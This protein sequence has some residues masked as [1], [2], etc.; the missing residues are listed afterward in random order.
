MRKEWN[1]VRTSSLAHIHIYT[2]NKCHFS[3]TFPNRIH[4]QGLR[5]LME[6]KTLVSGGLFP[7]PFPTSTA[8]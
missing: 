1:F 5:P 7:L 6:S 2:G 4:I 8:M 3:L